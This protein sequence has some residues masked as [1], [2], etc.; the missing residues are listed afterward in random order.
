MRNNENALIYT[1][2]T[3]A[4][5]DRQGPLRIYPPPSPRKPASTG[6]LRRLLQRLC[7]YL[8]S[9]PVGSAQVVGS[10]PGGDRR[11]PLAVNIPDGQNLFTRLGGFQSEFRFH[12]PRFLSPVWSGKVR[13]KSDLS[14]EKSGLESGPVR[15]PYRGN[16]TGLTGPDRTNGLDFILQGKHIRL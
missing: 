9:P 3:G 11:F 4:A 2:G 13:F 16:R 5:V 8:H 1:R 12:A 7:N 14:P 10:Q 15:F 6:H